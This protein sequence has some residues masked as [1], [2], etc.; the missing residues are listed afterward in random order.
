[1]PIKLPPSSKE[2]FYKYIPITQNIASRILNHYNKKI[3]SVAVLQ[4]TPFLIFMLI[5]IPRRFSVISSVSLSFHSFPFQSH[6]WCC[7]EKNN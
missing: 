4:H 1:M 3:T 5:S 7:L 6:E 2:K